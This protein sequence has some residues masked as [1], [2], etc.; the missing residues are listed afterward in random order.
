GWVSYHRGRDHNERNLPFISP[1]AYK[2]RLDWSPGDFSASVALSGA[3][4]QK[5][6]SAGFGEDASP[7]H[8]L[9][10]LSLG[11]RFSLAGDS[12]LVRAGVGNLFDR[13]YSTYS[14]WNNSLRMGRNVHMS[15]S[16]A[17]R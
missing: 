11:K 4:E 12:L 13:S 1:L 17:F 15:L 8:T 6:F 16:Y 7:A 14:D 5:N 10:S 3:L 9:V 2:G